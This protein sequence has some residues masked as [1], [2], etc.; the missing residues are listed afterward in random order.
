MIDKNSPVPIYYQIEEAIKSQIINGVLQPGDALPSEREYTEQYN[1]SRMTVRQAISNLVHAGYLYRQKGRG[2]FVSKQKIEK[3]LQGLTSFSE[4]M[5]ARGM[6]PGNRLVGFEI[7]PAPSSIARKLKI[8]EHTPIYE[9]KRIRLADDKPMAY[10]RTYIPANLVKGLTEEH[11][12]GSL[13]DYLEDTLNLVIESATH[14]IESSLT[15]EFEMKMLEVPEN[16]SIL[17]IKRQ[18][19]L[20]DGT[21]LEVVESSYRSDR[22]KFMTHMIRN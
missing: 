11:V 2:T 22:Y 19:F 9:I 21:P 13:Y 20:Q 5:R 1:I 12:K 18:T 8:E 14:E 4:D 6:K 17:L 15:N 7:I 10:E 3:N 16:S